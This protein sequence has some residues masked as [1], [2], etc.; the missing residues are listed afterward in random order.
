[1]AQPKKGAQSVRLE[2]SSDSSDDSSSDEEPA[3]PA[4][5][6]ENALSDSSNSDSDE[7]DEVSVCLEDIFIVLYFHLPNSYFLF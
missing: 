3:K 7:D 1:M 5:A 4:A 6:S 2:S